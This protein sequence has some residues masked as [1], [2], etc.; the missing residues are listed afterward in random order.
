MIHDV[1]DWQVFLREADFHNVTGLANARLGDRTTLPKEVREHLR[2]RARE[3][4]EHSLF[5]TTSL[6]ALSETF[7][8]VGITAVPFKGPSLA[9]YVYRNVGLR[10][11]LDL[12]FVVRR[13]DAASAKRLLEAEGFLGGP[14]A[15]SMLAAWIRHGRSVTVQRADGLTVDLQWA[16][17]LGERLD[18]EDLF[19]RLGSIDIAGAPLPMFSDEDLLLLL[20]I[21][22]AKHLWSHLY[23]VVDVAELLTVRPEL[24]WHRVLIAATS[25]GARRRLLVGLAL[26]QRL[27]RLDLPQGIMRSMAADT[28]VEVIA[29]AL[30]AGLYDDHA[31]RFPLSK[32]HLRM[33][34]SRADMLAFACRLGVTP[35]DDDWTWV[36]L[37]GNLW[38]LYPALRP[39]RLSAKYG[40]R[41][42]SSTT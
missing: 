32:W 5:L 42:L 11:S 19:T 23:W 20:C 2:R 4:G 41:L 34:D 24:D 1:R 31:H 14:K 21:H 40:R 15:G 36:Q 10:A 30:W 37:P 33:R 26:A 18:I 27:K 25:A 29:D 8:K 12:D 22:G 38:W 7:G 16:P 3:I 28:E 13:R 9:E 35:T 17:D 39:L 6:L